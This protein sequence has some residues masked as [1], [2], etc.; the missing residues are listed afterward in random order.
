M[1]P[2]GS[3]RYADECVR[4]VASSHPEIGTLRRDR[5]NSNALCMDLRGESAVPVP[6]SSLPVCVCVCVYVC[7]CV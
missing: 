4:S 6:A 1:R 3:E 7:M 5:N 2:N